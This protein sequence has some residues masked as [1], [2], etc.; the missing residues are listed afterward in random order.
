MEDESM[1]YILSIARVV[2]G[3]SLGVWLGAVVMT[4]ITAHYV[5]RFEADRN[6][7]GDIMGAI[8]HTAG[9]I[10]LALAALA[11]G[12]Q[13]VLRKNQA[14]APRSF[15]PGFI[16]LCLAFAL[17]L[18]VT[19]YL[20]PKMVD[21]RAQIGTFSE[22]NKELPERVLFGKLHGASMGLAVLETILVAIALVC[23]AL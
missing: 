8:L 2:R 9:W 5:F 23:L 4:F 6:K 22:A 11:L 18:L 20:E 10:K 1:K 16:A 17:A 14:S 21:L 7:A 12:A 19:L 3:L 13:L 15:K